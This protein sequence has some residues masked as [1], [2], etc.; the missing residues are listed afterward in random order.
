MQDNLRLQIAFFIV[1]MGVVFVVY[2]SMKN[3][4]SS[5]FLEKKIINQIIEF[6]SNILADVSDISVENGIVNIVGWL[7]YIGREDIVD[8]KLVFE[9]TEGE[10]QEILEVEQIVNVEF[11]ENTE[12][13]KPETDFYNCN[14]EANI[15]ANLLENDVCYVMQL[16]LIL[17]NDEKKETSKKISVSKYLYDGKVYS[18]NPKEF[19][20]PKFENKQMQSVIEDGILCGYSIQN[21]AWV[22]FYEKNLYWI[23]DKRLEQNLIQELYMFFHLYT[24]KVN[25]LP[26]Y[27]KQYG[28]DNIDFYFNTYEILLEN[29]DNYRVAK[30]SIEKEYPVTYILTGY[31]VDNQNLWSIEANLLHKK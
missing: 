12:Y 9:S 6:D 7:L 30:L 26:E 28:F 13:L 16:Y 21:G 31:Y 27:R 3:K 14:I 18:Y 5:D 2:F 24:T 23:L 8:V 17:Q 1:C 25:L 19:T 15:K 4:I 29:N 10:E 22:Y 20:K 11:L